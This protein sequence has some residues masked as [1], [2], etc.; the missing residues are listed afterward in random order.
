MKIDIETLKDTFKI[1]YE[2]FVDSRMEA[3]EILNLYHN[4][5]Y[6]S[7][8]LVTL[9]NRGQPPETFNIIKLY[10]RMLTGY[11]S[12]IINTINIQPVQQSDITKA[13]LVND[14]ID[15]IFRDNGMTAEGDKI[16]LD[17]ML[18]GLMVAYID[19][20]EQEETDEFG[21][22]LYKVKINH[23]PSEEIVLDPMSTE[24]DYSDARFLHRFKWVSQ[25]E[26]VRL[27]GQKKVDKLDSYSN[28]LDIQEAE[29]ATIYN[30][31]FSGYYKVF[32]NYLIVQTAIKDDDGKTWMIHWSG[33]EILF[34]KEL[35]YKE[36]KF[37]YRVE[38]LH[39]SNKAEYYGIFREILNTQH[40]INQALIKIQL[41]VN[42]E[43][44][45]YESNSVDNVEEFTEQI[46]RVNSVIKVNYLSGIKFEN[47]T[48]DIIDQYTII[49]KALD[50][51]QRVLGINDSFLGM[52]YASDSGRKVQLQQNQAAMSLRYVS[53]RFE[54][55]YKLLG[56]DIANLVKQYYT[57]H[58]VIR[59]SDEYAG[60]RWL[61]LNQPQQIWDGYT[62]G[63]DGMPQLYTP[64]EEVLDPA[65]GEV[66]TDE[67]GAIL[68]APATSPATNIAFSNIDIEITASSYND[69]D[70]QAQALIDNTLNGTVGGL[71]SQVNPAGFFKM[72]G[73]SIR[74][75]KVKGSEEMFAI[76]NNTSMMLNPQQQQAMQQG[77]LQGQVGGQSGN[78]SNATPR[79]QG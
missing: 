41:M 44:V 31:E 69:D 13:T 28:H 50:R 43:K 65:N 79:L 59:V 6:T 75:T 56:W 38:K 5:Q 76:L 55:F 14:T 77:Q 58:Q 15:Y 42:T 52:A 23:V 10:S 7:D 22:H 18:S 46:N 4:R 16:K 62:Y 27:Y 35:T 74:N 78:P 34:K 73:L 54:N 57:A 11:Y 12:T 24:D 37:P 30:N 40:S 61:E 48:K 60:N 49:D 26:A 68:M 36:V 66:K 72:A 17:G 3:L 63:P 33:D 51:V 32:D 20:Q 1:G 8:Q 71:L 21:R 9:E 2:T 67:D 39:T 19:A 29:F 45:L 47:L 25:D 64:M 53:S 70:E